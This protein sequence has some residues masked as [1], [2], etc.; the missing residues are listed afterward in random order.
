MKKEIIKNALLLLCGFSCCTCLESFGMEEKNHIVVDQSTS[1]YEKIFSEL[2]KLEFSKEQHINNNLNVAHLLESQIPFLIANFVK[3]DDTGFVDADD[4]TPY[5]GL[6]SQWINGDND[7]LAMPDFQ[8]FQRE[9]EDGADLFQLALFI[10]SKANIQS[11]KFSDDIDTEHLLALARVALAI[12]R[13]INYVQSLY[14]SF[15]PSALGTCALRAYRLNIKNILWVKPKDE[16]DQ[17]AIIWNAGRIVFDFFG[18]TESEFISTLPDTDEAKADV[19]AAIL[20]KIKDSEKRMFS[21][22]DTKYK[23]KTTEDPTILLLHHM[24]DNVHIWFKDEKWTKEDFKAYSSY[25]NGT[26]KK[27]ANS[28]ILIPRN[29]LPI[30]NWFSETLNTLS[31]ESQNVRTYIRD[32]KEMVFS[33]PFVDYCIYTRINWEDA[34]N[35]PIGYILLSINRDGSLK[36][37]YPVPY[38]GKEVIDI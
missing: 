22:E 8:N 21:E 27:T 37:M 16:F 4:T 2:K 20:K 35:N 25:K 17:Q 38:K 13:S 36:T 32:H 1:K 18:F 31:S 23:E 14:P 24:I 10:K 33:I 5:Q 9:Y 29:T 34:I 3:T 30:T 19:K 6:I 28:A 11:S 12:G 26:K 7:L 15:T